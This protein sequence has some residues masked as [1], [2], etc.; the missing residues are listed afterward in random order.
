MTGNFR[1]WSASGRHPTLVLAMLFTVAFA[2]LASAS[3]ALAAP[4]G[5][6][7]SFADCPLANPELTQCVTARTEGGLITIG[8]KTVEIKNTQTLQGGVIRHEEE[9][10]ALTFVGAADGNTLSKTAQTVPGGLLG[11]VAPAFLPRFLQELLN[12]F[13]NK[14]ITGVTATT[15]L[16]GP[17][18]SIQLSELNILE[19]SGTALRLP[20]KI[21]LSN[22]F[23]GNECYVGSNSH[24]LVLE[25]TTGTTSPPAPNEPISGSPGELGSR[26]EGEILSLSNN[27]LVD[28]SFGAPGASGC[29][30]ILSFLVDPA[31]DAELG[32]PST[33]GHNTAILN[34]SLEQTF[35]A[36]ARE[37]E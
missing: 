4:K 31:V 17:A 35:A 3:S 25:L 1:V 5:E 36:A 12:E 15:E 8:K 26:G 2:A 33:E 10:G 9:E 20:V 30:G 28:N 37:H 6:F 11:V 22:A 14:G 7:A 29:G 19:R 21:K 23:L 13:V 18:S 24:P 32:V 34:G 16:A 27:S